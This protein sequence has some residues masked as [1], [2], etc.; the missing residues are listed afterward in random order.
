LSLPRTQT[1]V[2][3][4][5]LQLIAEPLFNSANGSHLGKRI[6]AIICTRRPAKSFADTNQPHACLYALG[7]YVEGCGLRSS[8]ETKALPE[9]PKATWQG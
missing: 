4:E 6:A 1:I 5:T 9:Y 7:H 3:D 8:Q 2:T